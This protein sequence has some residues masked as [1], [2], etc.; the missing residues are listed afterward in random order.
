MLRLFHGFALLL[1]CAFCLAP[2]P[3]RSFER[4]AELGPLTLVRAFDGDS[5][6]LRHPE[7]GVLKAR[8]AGIDAP[9]K[10]QP[11]GGDARKR[12]ETLLA[13]G[14][15]SA[16]ALKL[17]GFGR[18]IVTIEVN[19]QDLG[20]TLIREGLAWYFRKYE[21]D[22]PKAL[23]PRYDAAE[24]QARRNKKGLWVHEDPLAPW[25]YRQKRSR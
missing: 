12:L 5:M 10:S 19:G 11:F 24:S 6:V 4:G 22:L 23:R 25:A 9:E 8:L 20:E 1:V 3:G 2:A 13:S 7:R 21:R 15:V 16:K 14:R 17:D 18:W